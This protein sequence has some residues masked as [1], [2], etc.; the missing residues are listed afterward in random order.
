MYYLIKDSGCK[1]DACG[2][3]VCGKLCGCTFLFAVQGI[4]V[5]NMK[6]CT[7]DQNMH[8]SI[9][10]VWDGGSFSG[11]LIQILCVRNGTV[12]TRW[13]HR[14]PK[15][16]FQEKKIMILKLWHFLKVLIDTKMC[17]VWPCHEIYGFYALKFFWM[18]K[19]LC[20]DWCG[21][22]MLNIPRTFPG[23]NSQR[24]L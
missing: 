16:L 21:L 11:A 1:G 10:F 18:F 7:F 8:W 5:N 4:K 20:E 9:P 12:V 24:K 22:K 13:D 19:Q 14:N 3:C 23:K 6:I 15:K 17:A 2:R